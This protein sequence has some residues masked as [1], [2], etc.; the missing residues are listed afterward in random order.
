MPPTQLVQVL[1]FFQGSAPVAF[2][3]SFWWP[4]S[5]MVPSSYSHVCN[6]I[7]TDHL[8]LSLFIFIVLDL[9]NVLILKLSRRISLTDL[10]QWI[11]PRL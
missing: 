1:P 4:I 5:L 6:N 7:Y 11:E 2:A 3:Q 8:T 9:I 10:A